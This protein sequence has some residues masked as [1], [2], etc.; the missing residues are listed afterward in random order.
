MQKD[1][2]FNRFRRACISYHLTEEGDRILVALSGGKDSLLLCDLLAR[3]Q[4]ILRPQIE[5]EAVHIVMENVPYQTDLEWLESW[6]NERGVKLHVLRTRFDL[7]EG[8]K[9]PPYFLCS[10][11]RRKAIF[12]FAEANKYNKVALGHHQDD[13]LITWL[14]NITFEGGATAMRPLMKMEHYPISVIRP[15]CL[16]PEPN[17]VEWAKQAGIRELPHKCPYERASR[18]S[19]A[20]HIFRQMEVLNPDVRSSMWHALGF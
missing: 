20:T 15:L 6:C 1:F 10:W 4:R 17:I 5:V 18:R 8:S 3:Q 9:K 16:V 7:H 14:M 2:L 12:Q 11:Y 13:I 19:D